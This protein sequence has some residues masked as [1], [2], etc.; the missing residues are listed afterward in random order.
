MASSS[1]PLLAMP[2]PVAAP[3]PLPTVVRPTT[4]P[5]L[6]DTTAAV[7]AEPEKHIPEEDSPEKNDPKKDT[8]EKDNPEKNSPE[9]DALA[10][11]HS[12][13]ATLHPAHAAFGYNG[14][15]DPERRTRSRDGRSSSRPKKRKRWSKLLWVKQDC[16]SRYACV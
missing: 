4:A 12:T 13:Q 1:P 16:M 14:A 10:W 11:P 15:H 9:K 6:T 5:L 7:A 2:T 8:P 3:A